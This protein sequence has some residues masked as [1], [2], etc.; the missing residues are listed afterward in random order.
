VAVV[1]YPSIALLADR[2]LFASQPAKLVAVGAVVTAVTPVPPC[3]TA[4]VV[5]A[6]VPVAI[7]PTVVRE[8]VTTV[9]FKVVP[10]R[11]PAGATTTLVL[12]AVIKPL[13]LTVKFGI[14]VL[15]PNAPV[16]VFTVERV[17]AA[18]PGPEAV[19][20]PVKAVR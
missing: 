17:R 18:L 6:Q 12:A 7:V 5:P 2:F 13:P 19:P 4:T 14:A 1:A 11:V 8:D 3:A 16:F 20:S 9:E 15:D 10:L